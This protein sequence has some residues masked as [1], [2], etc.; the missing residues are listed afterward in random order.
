MASDLVNITINGTPLQV[1]AG[2]MIIESAR[3]IGVEIPHFCYHPRLSKEAGANCRM[4]LVE[5]ASP[6]KNPDGSVTLAKMPKPQTS[7]SL[8]AGEGMV[9]ETE[10]PA[11]IEARRGILEF[12]LINHPLDC[13]ICDRGGECPLQNNTLHY[14]PPTTRYVEEK[15]H[16][17]KAFPL[18]E[19]VVLDRERC[20]HCARC[21]RFAEDIAGDAQLGFLKR[22]ADMEV[23]VRTGE[24]FTSLF[25][26]NTIELCPVGALLSRSYRFRGRPWDL[27]TQKSICTECS[28]GCN[29]KLDHRAGRF[30][31][32]NARLNE[33]VNE[34]WTCDRGKFGM[35][36]LSGPDRLTTPLVR[37]GNRFEAVGW[38]E[39]IRRVAEELGQAGRKS[40]F[41]GGIRSSNEDLFVMQRL[42]REVL[43][44]SDLDHRV[45]PSFD[46]EPVI[47][48]GQ[49]QVARAPMS[50]V[51]LEGLSLF[52]SFG[53]DM[54]WEQPMAYLRVRKGWRR[55]ALTIASVARHGT[56]EDERPSSLAPISAVRVRHD[57]GGELQVALRL[58]GEVLRQ[59]GD[60]TAVP[61]ELAAKAES[62]VTEQGADAEAVRRLALT[63][64]EAGKGASDGRSVAVWI[65]EAARTNRQLP[66]ILQTLSAALSAAGVHGVVQVPAM[67][68]NEQGARDLGI[69]PTWLPGYEQADPAGR[70]S[71]E[72]L[73]AVAQ[74]DIA[75]LWIS[76]LDLATRYS[77]PAAAVR[78]L[79][80]CP[81]LVVTDLSL[82]KTAQMADVVLPVTSVAER[83]GTYT[84]VEGRVQRFWKAYDPPA[85]VRQEWRIAA[86]IAARLGTEIHYASSR[87]VLADIA[88]RVPLYAGCGPDALGDGGVRWAS[89]LAGEVGR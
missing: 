55:G 14:G 75:A 19:H 51:E 6:R 56:A 10:T 36:Y 69:A 89:A 76:G 65:G 62:A 13:P 37:R 32:V 5:V 25:S 70:N 64:F 15:R 77:D 82:T 84:N 58:L 73:A 57:E 72:I 4:C 80:S 66:D 22:G 71:A 17:P 63:L 40:A 67:E 68:V 41:L 23:S 54:A 86:Q 61:A 81:F 45:G 87:E 28:N 33:D 85:G 44:S 8:P 53:C 59:G 83:N 79:E 39:A 88:A 7:C 2:E 34:E 38:D 60:G 3:R 20:I 47:G 42:F 27:M 30:V 49:G 31:R 11:I 74:G 26:G 1:P 12:L 16:L 43:G 29:I 48:V 46:A 21:T 24:Q 52:I 18:S 9:I 35:D 50:L 78:A